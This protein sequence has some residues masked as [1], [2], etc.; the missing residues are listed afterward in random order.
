MTC[1]SEAYSY[2]LSCERI[3]S[4]CS[5]SIWTLRAFSPGSSS[6]TST[7]CLS[8]VSTASICAQ[9]SMRAR[10]VLIWVRTDTRLRSP[11]DLRQ[12]RYSWS[13]RPVRMLRLWMSSLSHHRTKCLSRSLCALS[14]D[15]ASSSSRCCRYNSTPRS[16]SRGS[17]S[18]IVSWDDVRRP[19]AH[20][21]TCREASSPCPSGAC[22]VC[23]SVRQH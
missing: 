19:G 16:G 11:S 7:D 22:L 21:V 5:E 13:R 17:S 2:V 14:D 20:S 10:R 18:D 1:R 12:R 15:S 23:L 3:R 4:A 6:G 8:P 9:N